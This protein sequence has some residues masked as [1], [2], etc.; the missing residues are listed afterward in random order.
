MFSCFNIFYNTYKIKKHK[1]N[2]QYELPKN[3]YCFWHDYETDNFIK[4]FIDNWKKKCNDWN[5]IVLHKNNVDE[6]TNGYM[7]KYNNLDN[8]K[9]SDFLRLYLLKEY[10]G[11]WID[12]STIILNGKFLDDYRN[13]MI[14][15]QYD[16]ML[17]EYSNR[18]VNKK[19]PYFESWFIM[20]PKNS[21]LIN[22]WYNIFQ[23]AFDIGF[24]EFKKN[25]LIPSGLDLSS[26]ITTNENDIYLFIHACI[27]YLM[28]NDNHYNI[29]IKNAS[30][31]MFKI[32]NDTQWDNGKILN[33]I[34]NKNFNNMYSVKLV[35][36][37][38]NYLKQYDCFKNTIK[39]I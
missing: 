16:C 8:T 28:Y 12:I 17:Y 18:T 27:N 25:I 33:E 7:K 23:D 14:Q 21:R 6:Y 3:I 38:R 4:L 22:D 5:I 11:V 24:V 34:C 31:S 1:N 9:Y 35:G 36:N 15:N 26:T 39:D 13:E 37:Q 2:V 30:E 32:Q 19:Y 10:G 29:L 20:A